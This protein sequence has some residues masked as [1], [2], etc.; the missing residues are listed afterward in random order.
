MRINITS[1]LVTTGLS[2]LIAA[3]A[4]MPSAVSGLPMRVLDGKAVIPASQTVDEPI[5]VYDTPGGTLTVFQDRTAVWEPSKDVILGICEV[6]DTNAT[7]GE[8][9][10]PIYGCAPMVAPDGKQ[11]EMVFADDNSAHYPGSEYG[12]DGEDR[13]FTRN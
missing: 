12:F 4:V 10:E 7:T 5:G 3:A 6:D 2:A 1:A 13:M 9:H 11:V 8:W